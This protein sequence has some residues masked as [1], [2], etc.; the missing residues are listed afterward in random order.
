MELDVPPLPT[1]CGALWGA[2][3]ELNQ[4]RASNG[5][6]Y[7]AISW[8]D[9]QAWQQVRRVELS[10][11]ELETIQVLD[12]IALKTLNRKPTKASA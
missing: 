5:A 6:G 7:C 3:L 12:R 11:W 1:G 2:F 9:V 8:R 4:A 10:G